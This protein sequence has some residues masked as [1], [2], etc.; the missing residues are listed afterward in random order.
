MKFIIID[1]NQN[2]YFLCCNLNYINKT[3]FILETLGQ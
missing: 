3:F 1:L 2:F